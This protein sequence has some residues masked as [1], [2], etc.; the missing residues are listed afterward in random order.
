MDNDLIKNRFDDID[1]KLDTM[2]ESCLKL[3]KENIQLLSRIK[4][5]EKEL[6]AK[7]NAEKNLSEQDALIQSKIDGLLSKLDSFDSEQPSDPSLSLGP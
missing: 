6:E 4:E 5:M 1:L 2:I 3:K 7:K